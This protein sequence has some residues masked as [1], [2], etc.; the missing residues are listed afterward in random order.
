MLNKAWTTQKNA[1]PVLKARRAMTMLSS[2]FAARRNVP[3][4]TLSLG[5]FSRSRLSTPLT[6]LLCVWASRQL[7]GHFLAAHSE[8]VHPNDPTGF[9]GALFK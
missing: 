3:G 5:S 2:F 9:L 8:Y 1:F 4:I 6:R 7:L